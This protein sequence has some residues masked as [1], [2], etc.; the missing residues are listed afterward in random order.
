MSVYR[1][2]KFRIMLG[3]ALCFLFIKVALYIGRTYWGTMIFLTGTYLFFFY[4]FFSIIDSGI[5][6]AGVFHEK[7]NNE[8]I[9]KQPLSFFMKNRKDIAKLYKLPFNLLFIYCAIKY[10]VST[11]F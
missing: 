1:N 3:V 8:N 4:T 9:K 10:T 11:F 2:R 7:H 5:E 6:K